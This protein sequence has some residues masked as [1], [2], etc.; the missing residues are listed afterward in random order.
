KA[1]K[2]N[3]LVANI[4]GDAE[5]A[6]ALY[7]DNDEAIISRPRSIIEG[8]ITKSWAEENAPG[9]N[10]IEE[11]YE[12]LIKNNTPAP[13]ASHCNHMSEDTEGKDETE[14]K[15]QSVSLEDIKQVC[16]KLE[17]SLQ[18]QAQKHK[19]YNAPKLK[20][21]KGFSDVVADI[22]REALLRRRTYRRPSR[23]CPSSNLLHKGVRT[24]KS[25]PMATVYVDRSGSFTADKTR[26]A[27]HEMKAMAYR[28][29]AKL[30]VDF[31]FFSDSL[32]QS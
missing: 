30:D 16:E 26:L 31:I 23:R 19:L 6:I 4:A 14:L 20:R 15:E 28:Y 8:G 9:A 7:D 32:S 12:K 22:A 13:N 1:N 17:R 27:E 2:W 25:R 3:P 29:R 18:E 21:Q 5:I 10:T 24:Q 11:I